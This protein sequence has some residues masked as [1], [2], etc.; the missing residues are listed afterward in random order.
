M[1]DLKEAAGVVKRFV[2]RLRPEYARHVRQAS[3]FN[4]FLCANPLGTVQDDDT[5]KIQFD[6]DDHDPGHIVGTIVRKRRHEVRHNPQPG[7]SHPLSK[8]NN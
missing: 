4:A 7:E 6:E 1:L 5:V 2:P 8:P 3:S